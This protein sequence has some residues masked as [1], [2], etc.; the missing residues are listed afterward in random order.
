MNVSERASQSIPMAS[1]LGFGFY[2]L[3]EIGESAAKQ[4]V[5]DVNFN[6]LLQI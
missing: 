3:N 1:S 5:S 6:L 4:G 2:C